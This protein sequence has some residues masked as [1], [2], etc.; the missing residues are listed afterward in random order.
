VSISKTLLN[1]FNARSKVFKSSINYKINLFFI[2][3]INNLKTLKKL[4]LSNTATHDVCQKFDFSLVFL[5][6]FY[7][8]DMLMLKINF[9]K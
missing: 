3:H 2:F 5:M 4:I 8:F 9:K 6:F 1:H 7:Y